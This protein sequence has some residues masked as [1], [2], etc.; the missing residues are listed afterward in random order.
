MRG[1]PVGS[2]E[3]RAMARLLAQ[4]QES[5]RKL[6]WRAREKEAFAFRILR[7]RSPQHNKPHRSD[8]FESMDGSGKL[9]CILWVP[10]DMSVAEARRIVFSEAA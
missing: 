5:E 6:A 8:W 2:P 9:I 7:P 1:F 10:L 3:S 4:R